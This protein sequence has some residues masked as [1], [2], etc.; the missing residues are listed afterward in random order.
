MKKSR[1]KVSVSSVSVIEQLRV[2]MRGS[3]ICGAIPAV[4]SLA[5]SWGGLFPAAPPLLSTPPHRRRRA[6]AG[7]RGLGK[8][9]GCREP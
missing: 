1:Q 3:Q 4:A 2:L 6:E 7:G 8:A 5:R 9:W